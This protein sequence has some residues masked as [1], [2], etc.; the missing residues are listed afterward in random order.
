MK[1]HH[2]NDTV[3]NNANKTT[4]IESKMYERFAATVALPILLIFLTLIY[5]GSAVPV[6]A[7]GGSNEIAATPAPSGASVG[8]AA[9]GTNVTTTS[10]V[11]SPC[12]PQNATTTGSRTVNGTGAN[13]TTTNNTTTTTTFAPGGAS[14][15]AND[16]STSNATAGNTT[17][18]TTNNTTTATVAPSGASIC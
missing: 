4:A 7:T 5:A 3:N 1:K 18:A 12:L 2:D 13:A 11:Q 10:D 6:Q 17:M 16:T 8:T 14:I 9:E 15:G